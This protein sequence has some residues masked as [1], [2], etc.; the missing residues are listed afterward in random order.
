MP[1]IGIT[2]PI[3]SGKSYVSKL[4]KKRGVP[5]IDADQVYHRLVGKK[6]YLT[7]EL[8]KEF[9]TDVLNDDGSLNRKKL[10][11]IVF[12]DPE[13]LK[14]LN[15]L[16]HHHVLEMILRRFY[17]FAA[18]GYSYVVV[19][20]PLMFES[21]F[22]KHCCKII[23]VIADEDERI[24]RIMKRNNLTEDEAKKRVKNQKNN[25][26]YIANSNYIVYNNT[27]KGAKEDFERIYTEIFGN[28]IN[29][30]YLE[31]KKNEPNL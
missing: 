11:S 13:K 1:I 19:E 4:F 16:T 14:R 12:E 22:D 17:L 20:V 15:S 25:D 8:G 18:K 31:D 24:R 29:N 26:F 2:G 9:G 30:K 27:Y 23:S 10:A 21:G 5:T 7:E 28:F 6:S 3:G